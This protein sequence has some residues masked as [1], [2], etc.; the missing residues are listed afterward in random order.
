MSLTLHMHPLASYCWK[1]LI[2]LYENGT[3]FRSHLVDLGDEASRTAFQALVPQAKMPVLQDEGRG[4]VVPESTIIIDYLG[5][6]HP[7]PIALIPADPDTAWRTRLRDRYF[8]L[9][10]HEPMQK[11][12]GDRI[13]P[14]GTQDPHGV[15]AAHAT[16]R[17]SYATIERDMAGRQWAMGEAFTLADCAA[18]PALFYANKVEPFRADRP[19][20]TAYL[21]RLST[22]P[23]I[24]RV[25]EEA[26][27]YFH[28]FPG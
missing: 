23:S 21:D 13:R 17:A 2:A 7:G 20:L 16:L 11:I 3:P 4:Q 28:M 14:P 19:A 18:F 6:Y 5:L 24:A 1:V 9:Y 15:E 12:V 8:D 25:V 26:K 22:R 10:V 27:P